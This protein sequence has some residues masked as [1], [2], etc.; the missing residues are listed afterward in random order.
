MSASFND[1]RLP[2]KFWSKVRIDADTGCWLWKAGTNV[3]GYGAF[4]I[5]ETGKVVRSH[6][7]AYEV[8]VG[9][10]PPGLEIDHLCRVR[11]CLNPAHLEPVTHK[12]NMRRSPMQPVMAARNRAKTHCPSGH[13]YGGDNLVIAA[14]GVNRLCRI[15]RREKHRIRKAAA[16]ANGLCAACLRRAAGSGV[17]KCDA[18]RERIRVR[19]RMGGS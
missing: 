1:G 10:I 17:T 5:T 4:R 15:C 2:A 19:R 3:Y 7:L 16:I 14:D 6:R 9:E 8:L 13:E 11:A 18:C 12:E